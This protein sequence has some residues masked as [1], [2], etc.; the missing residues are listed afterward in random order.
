MAKWALRIPE[1]GDDTVG[2]KKPPLVGTGGGDAFLQSCIPQLSRELVDLKHGA[3][4][5]RLEAFAAFEGFKFE[6][7]AV[8]VQSRQSRR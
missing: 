8:T 5:L 3:P 4:G 7:I 1:E 6:A 2:R